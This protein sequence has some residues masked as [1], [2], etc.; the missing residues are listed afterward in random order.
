M[1]QWNNIR[2][3][4]QHRYLAILL[5]LPLLLPTSSTAQYNIS[6]TYSNHGDINAARYEPSEL[7]LG[8]DY[9]HVGLNYY[10]WVANNALDY[11]SVK[12]INDTSFVPS[13][14]YI[15]NL[16]NKFQKNNLFGAGQ[17]FQVLGIAFQIVNK[18]G[19]KRYDFSLS[20]VDKFAMNFDFTKNLMKLA[21][22]GNEQ[23]R[24]ETVELGPLSLNANYT[25]EYVVGTAFPVTGSRDGFGVRVGLRAKYIQGMGSILMPKSKLDMTTD[26]EGRY[27]DIDY[28]Y[29]LKTSGMST[30]SP[31]KY[32]GNGFGIDAGVSLFINKNFEVVVSLLDVGGVKYVNDI[33]SYEKQG[34]IRYKGLIISNFLGEPDL[35]SQS[36]SIGSLFLPEPVP[37]G[38]Y[39]MPSATR[40]IIQAEYKTATRGRTRIDI[41][42]NL[43][44][45]SNAFFITYIQG[46]NN[47]PGATTKP[48][49]SIAYNHDFHKVF[50]I[51]VSAAVGGYN[52]LA[53]GA[54]F[55]LIVGG[56]KV[57]VGSDN[58]TAL[59][60]D[61][62]GTGLDV[63]VNLSMAFTPIKRS[64]LTKHPKY[65]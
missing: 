44:F 11:R 57:G 39:F 25:R 27:I 26:L 40:I 4:I 15:E 24:G 53:L 36:D 7:D 20:V 65:F 29:Q 37:G 31:F 34:S 22:K 41:Q 50:D 32:N 33:T 55:S 17:D 14:E 9:L 23:F 52:N 47:M 61:K 1:K 59:V 56:I 35:E 38:S 64:G 30:L 16:I 18:E 2:K 43:E 10:L 5:L 13:P 6:T 63:S 19:D 54:F 45:T 8:Y 42:K 12:E 28:D 49:F 3:K 58:L 62:L 48:F 46:L 21:W 51:G 60:Y